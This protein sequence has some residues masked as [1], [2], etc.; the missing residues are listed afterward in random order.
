MNTPNITQAKLTGGE[1]AEYKDCKEDKTTNRNG[2]DLC[3]KYMHDIRNVKSLDEEM[4]N[5]VRN[6]LNE[7]KMNIIISFNEMLKYF[8]PLHI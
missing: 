8:T 1:R 4:I 3:K 2:S 6:M 5:N 7:E